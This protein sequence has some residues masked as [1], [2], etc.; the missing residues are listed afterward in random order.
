MKT[1]T[2]KNL[3]KKLVFFII[4]ILFCLIIFGVYYKTIHNSF[5]PL[6]IC[7]D[8]NVIF[9]SFDTLRASNVGIYGYK[10]NTT[11]TIDRLASEGYIFTNAISVA[12]WTLPS[13]MSWF[14]GVYPSVH[15]VLNKFTVFKD[16]KEEISNVRRLSPS[17]KTL[18]EIF[19]EAGYKTGAFTGGAGVDRQFGFD[20]GFDEY[21][22][23]KDFGGFED[24]VPQALNW[25]NKNKD[26]KL[27]VFLHGYNIHGQ[28]VPQ[29]GYDRRFVNNN[30]KGAL[31][32]SKD[33][34][35]RLREDGLKLGKN[36]LTKEDVFFLTSIYDEKIQRADA[37]FSKFI[38]EYK[39]TGLYEKTIFIL[40]SD[41]GDE[42]Y[43]HNR[44]DHGHS[45]Y[46]ELIRVPL[47]IKMPNIARKNKITSQVSSIDI[48]PTIINL[49][50][51]KISNSVSNQ[52]EG[53]SL[54]RVMAGELLA[55]DVYAETDYRYAT[56]QRGIRTSDGWKYIYNLENKMSELYN[57][58]TDS[59]EQ[60]NL[61]EKYKDIS[62]KLQN[63]IDKEIKS[64]NNSL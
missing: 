1:I 5:K 61:N 26:K 22:D 35:L 17:L 32:A 43:E 30:Y 31:T 6:T 10:R 23:K 55:Q 25:I 47:I 12:P 2:S 33:E 39:K 11:S 28:Y 56:F 60:I 27:F 49:V 15:K 7:P 64:P 44:I 4:G 48:M 37:E 21:Y 13:T 3:S 8:C 45:L 59:S 62:T 20:I 14:T 54:L 24:S 46:D 38:E 42:F 51:I 9:V 16:G 36:F 57:L 29:G 50:G 63:K 58:R 41:H 53:K 18:A 19:Q 52:M 40:T 34:Q